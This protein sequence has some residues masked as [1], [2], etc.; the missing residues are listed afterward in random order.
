MIESQKGNASSTV[1]IAL[2]LLDSLFLLL[3]NAFYKIADGY[4]AKYLSIV[5]YWQV[6]DIIIC[7]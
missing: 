2:K 3:D 5:N 6:S 7:H 4:Q 1:N